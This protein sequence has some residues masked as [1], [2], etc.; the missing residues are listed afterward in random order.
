[1]GGSSHSLGGHPSRSTGHS[2]HSSGRSSKSSG[3]TPT[4]PTRYSKPAQKEPS[5]KTSTPV[6]PTPVPTTP[7][8]QNGSVGWWLLGGY[9]LGKSSRKEQ[10]IQHIHYYKEQA[11]KKEVPVN[12]RDI[13]DKYQSCWQNNSTDFKCDDILK[14]FNACLEKNKQ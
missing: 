11:N 7:I 9:F 8:P 4:N 3:Y 1:M 2:S 6:A 12:C 14:D 13:Y 10:E 5:T